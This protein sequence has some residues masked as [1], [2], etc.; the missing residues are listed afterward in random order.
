MISILIYFL[1]IVAVIMKVRVM[2]GNNVRDAYPISSI[3]RLSYI[4]FSGEEENAMPMFQT[5]EA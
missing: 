5:V 3:Q 4:P 1:L 2:I